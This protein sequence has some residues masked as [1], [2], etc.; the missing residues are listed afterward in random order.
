[1]Y[2]EW[3]SLFCHIIWLHII[4]LF[5]TFDA[6][7]IQFLCM[8]LFNNKKDPYARG[9]RK[10]QKAE[11]Q[12]RNAELKR[13]RRKQRIARW[14]KLR[15]NLANFF[16]NPFTKKQ[17]TFEELEKQ[18][19]KRI[20]KSYKN[21]PYAKSDKIRQREEKRLVRAK[22]KLARRK[23]RIARR[24][25][26]LENILN[27]FANPLAKEKLSLHEREQLR[28]KRYWKQERR[29]DLRKKLVKFIKKPHQVLFPPKWSAREIGYIPHQTKKDRALAAKKRRKEMWKNFK[30]ILSTPDVRKKFGIVFLQSTAYYVLAFLIVYVVYQMVTILVASVFDIP[31][32]WYYYQLK[33]PLY[34]YSKLY[35]R[36]ALVLIFGTGPIVSLTLAF[37]FLKAF[38]N[39]R[40]N[41]NHFQLFSLWGIINGT[42][43]F[44]G[45]YIVGFLTRTEFIYTS[46]WLLMSSVFDI[47]EMLFTLLSIGMLLIIGRLLTPLFLVSSG[48]ITLLTPEYRLFFVFSQVILPWIAG[49]GIFFLIVTPHYYIPFLLKTLTPGL[50]VI[51][52]LFT[53]NTARNENIHTSGLIRRNYFR[54]SI[55]IAVIALLF[56]YRIALNF[57]LKLN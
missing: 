53:Y 49:I 55:V 25:E 32:Q 42:N 21:S 11:K 26:F 41:S 33:F 40:S 27:Y 18:R 37:I 57:G 36:P 24:K 2:N 19:Q 30:I 45:A 34:T 20:R 43:M 54:W 48:S 4:A 28:L 5:S 12:R 46:E 31:V 3:D 10:R 14:Q 1:M 39:K 13:W 35:T 50:I 44:F 8:G 9:D 29:K 23:H 56:F 17:P 52:S 6:S 51:P 38:F 47:E 15:Q 16:S 7:L 22:V